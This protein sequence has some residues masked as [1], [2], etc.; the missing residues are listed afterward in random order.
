M[1][2]RI[3]LLT[4]LIIFL[5]F[6]SFTIYSAI[7]S[8]PLEKQYETMVMSGK[9]NGRF[10][11]ALIFASFG[12]EDILYLQDEQE[13][14]RETRYDQ[15]IYYKPASGATY[16]YQEP[17]EDLPQVLDG[18]EI[19]EARD[20]AARLVD[21][22]VYQAG[23][24]LIVEAQTNGIGS[25]YVVIEAKR[26]DGWTEVARKETSAAEFAQ[27]TAVI[28]EYTVSEQDNCVRVKSVFLLEDAKK[29]QPVKNT[30]QFHIDI[31]ELHRHFDLT[32][33]FVL[34]MLPILIVTSIIIIKTIRRNRK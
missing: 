17:L 2:R 16:T 4:I 30:F 1:D 31:E 7:P 26:S 5:V 29:E 32:Y 10:H 33:L 21:R 12:S 6:S 25:Y 19:L 20:G 8:D 3:K 9:E 13:V 23:D 14:S 22:T 15:Y 11:S 27:N 28:A 18:T 34:I 24:T